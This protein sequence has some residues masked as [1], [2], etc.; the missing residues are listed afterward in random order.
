MCCLPYKQHQETVAAQNRP[1]LQPTDANTHLPSARFFAPHQAIDHGVYPEV[2]HACLHQEVGPEEQASKPDEAS[3]TGVP[4]NLQL[5]QDSSKKQEAT[6]FGGAVTIMVSL[7]TEFL[8][9]WNKPNA[10]VLG[11]SKGC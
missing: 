7:H 11:G 2:A 1:S 6:A 5:R 8:Y 9:G 4:S 10:K 3:R